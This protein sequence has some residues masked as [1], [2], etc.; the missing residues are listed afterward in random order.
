MQQLYWISALLIG[1]AVAV[2]YCK[3]EQLSFFNHCTDIHGDLK[4][5]SAV[6]SANSQ[7]ILY[8]RDTCID[9][10]AGNAAQTSTE[11]P[12]LRDNRSVFNLF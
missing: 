4:R 2:N 3:R 7:N 5:Q 8:P 11:P 10:V 6:Q 12:V 1:T 9:S